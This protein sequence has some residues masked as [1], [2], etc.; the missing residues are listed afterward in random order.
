MSSPNFL[1]YS[2]IYFNHS[3][4]YKSHI[5]L[6]SP[7]VSRESTDH[8]NDA[9]LLSLR[10][11]TTLNHIRF[12]VYQDNERNLCQDLMTTENSDLQKQ[13]LHYA[14]VVIALVQS[15]S[16]KRHCATHC[17]KQSGMDSYRQLKLANQ[18]AKLIAIVE[19][20]V[21]TTLPA[22]MKINVKI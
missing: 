7:V 5:T 20:G 13:A 17:W 6:G 2:Y 21:H 3:L 4:L 1:T 14:K 22:S 12:V 11:Q 19:K 18:I 8:C 10:V 15:A 16:W 9:Y